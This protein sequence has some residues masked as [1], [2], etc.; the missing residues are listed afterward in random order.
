M[1]VK[2]ITAVS[3]EHGEDAY[4]ELIVTCDNGDTK[5]VVFGDMEPEDAHL[6]RDLS[7]AYNIETLVKMAYE[8]GKRG[9]EYMYTEEVDEDY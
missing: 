6:F 1:K 4:F 5:N 9:E 3:D 8:A 2:Q 7:D